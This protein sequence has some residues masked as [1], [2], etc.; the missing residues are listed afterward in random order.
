MT[1]KKRQKE[2]ALIYEKTWND[3]VNEQPPWKKDIIINNFQ[4][5]SG[6][7]IYHSKADQ[8]MMKDIYDTVLSRAEELIDIK[9]S[10]K[11]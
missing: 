2:I 8:R 9:F 11:Y 7:H 1:P 6:R 4:V 5:I 10:G 3:V